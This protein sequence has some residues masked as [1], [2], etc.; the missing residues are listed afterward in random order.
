MADAEKK[1]PLSKLQ[2]ISNRFFNAYYI[3]NFLVLS[4]YLIVRKI[5]PSQNLQ[6]H[7]FYDGLTR[8]IEILLLMLVYLSKRW[9]RCNTVDD[10][11]IR[12]ILYFKTLVIVYMWFTDTRI[13]AW[14][15][16]AYVVIFMTLSR[17]E[18]DGPVC[19]EELT[20]FNFHSLVVNEGDKRVMWL[21]LFYASWSGESKNFVHVFADFALRYSTPFLKFGRV[22]V[23]HSSLAEEFNIDT[24]SSSFQLPSLILFKCGKE[25]RR[26]PPLNKKGEVVATVIGREGAK[27]YLNLEYWYNKTRSEDYAKNI[28]HSLSKKKHKKK[29]KK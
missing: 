16:I 14:Y 27:S 8:E 18:Y 1:Q 19:F 26:L 15:L 20:P 6:T 29:K 7:D 5:F 12:A 25:H 23:F 10:F 3:I 24:S 2:S 28:V 22:N 17:P 9:K 4:S 21:V 13:M 11:V